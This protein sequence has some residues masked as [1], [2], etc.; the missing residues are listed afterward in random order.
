MKFT[1]TYIEED[2]TLRPLKAMPVIYSNDDLIDQIKESLK[3]PSVARQM[4][5][6]IFLAWDYERIAR[7]LFWERKPHKKTPISRG[8]NFI[9]LLL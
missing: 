8:F 4:K 7:P 3:L 9:L 5:K 1:T 6:Q 2:E